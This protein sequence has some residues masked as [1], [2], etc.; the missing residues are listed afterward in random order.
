MQSKVKQITPEQAKAALWRRGVLSWKLRPEQQKLRDLL[1]HTPTDLACFNVSRRF[2]KSTTCVT[3]CI[4]QAIKK[5]QKIL[6]A[7]AFLTDLENFICPIFEWCLQDCPDDQRPIW[8]A[9]KKE[10]HFP[11]G[12]IIKLIGLDKNAN[13]LRGNN[14]D[15]IVIDEAA[16]VKNLEYLYK[17]VIIP[18]TMKRKFKLIFPST[19][20]ESPEHFWAKELIQKAK[21]KN[22]YIEL[23]IDDIS[24]LPPEERKRLLDEV[25][26]EQSP[27]AQRE[28][29][30]K[31]IVDSTRAIAP[32]FAN[33]HIQKYHPDHVKWM[34]FGDA[35]GV[36]DKTVFLKV[37]FDHSIGKVIFKDELS[38]NPGTPTTKIVEEY[39]RIFTTELSLILDAPG[40][41]LI[42]Y[43]SLGLPASLPPKDDFN[44]GLLLLNNAFHNNT[45]IINP[46]CSLLIRTL[47]GGLLNKQRSDY[48]RSEALGHCDAVA[49]AIYALRA[50]DR[51]TDLRPKPKREQVFTLNTEPALHKNL[52]GLAFK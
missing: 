18:A 12:S 35:G 24:D 26:G 16:F 31:I 50:V 1:E 20:P 47:Q 4:E 8:K 38:F 11:D 6:Y 49:A 33:T 9:S 39:K 23:T 15:I 46:E 32:S 36:K 17:S 37:G 34:I 21:E 13:S 44:A 19:P 40:Q 41:L 27:T 42:D 5:K 48:E 25:G 51:T 14:I 7:T 22:T 30:C 10:Y 43:S 29:F 2:G 52:K 3:F 45:V 28:F